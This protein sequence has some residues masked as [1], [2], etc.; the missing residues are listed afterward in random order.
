MTFGD[1]T[2]MSGMFVDDTA[3]GKHKMTNPDGST[4]I[5]EFKNGV[6]VE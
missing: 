6:L 2:I 1:G 5:L 4:E 3:E